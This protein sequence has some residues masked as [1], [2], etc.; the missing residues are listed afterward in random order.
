MILCTCIL[1]SGF[2]ALFSAVG[3]AQGRTCGSDFFAL[4]IQ[5]ATTEVNRTYPDQITRFIVDD[6]AIAGA[7]AA[8]ALAMALCITL[9]YALGLVG[10]PEKKCLRE[11]YGLHERRHYLP[12]ADTPV[13]EDSIV[14]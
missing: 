9:S 14:A 4:A 10:L 8:V 7:I 12:S 13:V 3:V 11:G 6:V 2:V 5:A 1:A